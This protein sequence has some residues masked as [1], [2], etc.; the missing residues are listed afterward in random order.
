MKFFLLLTFLVFFSSVTQSQ[1][2]EERLTGKWKMS[3]VV[4][5]GQDVTEKHNP[6]GNRYFIFKRD[7][8]F[9]SGGD[10]Y[11]INTGRFFV[12]NL[13]Q[14]LFIDSNVGPDD[15][16]MWYVSIEGE[17]LIW[18]GFGTEWAE[19]FELIHVRDQ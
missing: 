9:E 1:N 11:G 2:L 5:G 4:Q 16:S 15:D 19:G 17:K 18:K 12:N 6:K 7:G 14:S 3:K 8:T 10:P 13:Q